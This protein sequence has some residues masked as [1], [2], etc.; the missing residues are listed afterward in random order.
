ME[1]LFCCDF[2]LLELS[3]L[4]NTGDNLLL[5][6]HLDALRSRLSALIKTR[7]NVVVNRLNFN[8]PSAGI[9]TGPGGSDDAF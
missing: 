7:T 3:L 5:R 9:Q 6:R 2:L 4:G 1:G 8:I